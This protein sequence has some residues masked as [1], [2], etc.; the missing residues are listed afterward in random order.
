MIIYHWLE[1]FRVNPRPRRPSVS[2]SRNLTEGMGRRLHLGCTAL[3]LARAFL[4]FHLSILC[5]T[6]RHP[7]WNLQGLSLEWA[8]ALSCTQEVFRGVLIFYLLEHGPCMDGQSCNIPM[9]MLGLNVGNNGDRVASLVQ[10]LILGWLT[11]DF[12]FKFYRLSKDSQKMSDLLSIFPLLDTRVL[13]SFHQRTGRCSMWV[14]LW[15]MY[16]PTIWAKSRTMNDNH[17]GLTE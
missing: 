6:T 8:S 17:G 4:P 14:D 16:L 13:H 5:Y 2:W 1:T 3:L 15:K 10:W 9:S 11:I 12:D 7:N